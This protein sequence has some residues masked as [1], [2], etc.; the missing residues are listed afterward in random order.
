MAKSMTTIPTRRNVGPKLKEEL[1]DL[2]VQ[3]SGVLQRKAEVA[4]EEKA[5]KDRI[6]EIAEKFDLPISKDASQYLNVPEAGKAL[7]ITRPE[8]TP[9]I[10]PEAF[11][12][13]VGTDLFH[14]LVTVLKVELKLPE[15][16]KAVE[17]ERVTQEQLMD[18]IKPIDPDAPDPITISLAKLVD[19][20]G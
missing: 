2:T 8:P 17:D 15:W 11:R 20:K 19:T 7:R 18:C 5:I 3:L 12:Q 13:R 6:R 4:K 14:E 10:E 9:I 16:L 1:T